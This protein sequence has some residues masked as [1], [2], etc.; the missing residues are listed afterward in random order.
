MTTA[1][2][3]PKHS[4]KGV[5]AVFFD[6][7]GTLLFPHPSVGEV[8]ARVAGEHGLQAQPDVLNRIFHDVWHEKDGLVT[9]V[10]ADEKSEKN[11]WREI[12]RAVFAPVGKFDDFDVFFDDLYHQFASP[13]TWRLFEET[14]SVLE[15]FK[16]KGYIIGMISNWDRRL[17]GLCDALDIKK[18]FDF[19]L[20]SALYGKAKPHQD[21]FG[22]ALRL[23]GVSPEEALHV[24]DSLEDDVQGARKAG[25]RAL[26][27][28]R[29]GRDS[30]HV[31]DILIIQNLKEMIL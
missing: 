7:G 19:M 6:A 5:K 1:K 29:H 8:Y 9:A 11:W 30:K 16:K 18:Y 13:Q 25:I 24:G 26:W 31:N 28:N 3:Q 2:H 20:I 23:A 10:F 27:L 14:H 4:L 22:E 17:I 21:I 15:H 12:V